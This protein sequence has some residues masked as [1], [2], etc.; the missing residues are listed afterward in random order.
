MVV[1]LGVFYFGQDHRLESE[2][3]VRRA[4]DNTADWVLE[5]GYR[6]VL[7]EIN[8][9]CDCGYH[10]PLLQPKYVHELIA[11]VKQ[12]QRD[13]HRLLVSTSYGGGTV[14]GESVV[15]AADFLLLHGNGV[16]EPAR[17]AALVRQARAVPGYRPMPVLVNEDDHFDFDQSENN[18]GAAL[19]EYCSWGYF[20]PGA[21]NYADGYQC[22]PVNWGLS[23]ARKRAFFAR[24]REIAGP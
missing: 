21:S 9:E 3:A 4:V 1:I 11:Q 8:N 5:S 23:T 13:G 17:L 19:S 20:D 6:N 7:L 16:A 10:H 18:F 12:R 2:A 15:R 22:P 24:V 14:P